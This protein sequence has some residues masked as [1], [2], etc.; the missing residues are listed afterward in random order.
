MIW[1]DTLIVHDHSSA[2][3]PP[4]ESVVIPWRT[5]LLRLLIRFHGIF[6]PAIRH[7]SGTWLL[8]MENSL[9]LALAD[10]ASVVRLFVFVIQTGNQRTCCPRIPG[11]DLGNWS[12]SD[13]R[14]DAKAR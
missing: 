4:Q 1:A 6:E 7:F 13:K 14:S 8:P 11:L 9:S 5:Q 10:D 3:V 12:V 2:R